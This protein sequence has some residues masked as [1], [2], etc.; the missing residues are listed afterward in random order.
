MTKVVIFTDLDGTLLDHR[1]YSFEKAMPALE[2]IRLGAAYPDLRRALLDLQREGFAV[3]G[4]GDM[5]P[6]EV[7]DITNLDINEAEMAKKRD[8][9][10]PF[11]YSGSESELAGLFD[12]I[13]RKGF[14]CT[15]GS[16]FH[17][18]GKSDKGIA[19]SI[20]AEL[21]RQEYGAV[22]TIALG[23]SPNDIPMLQNVDCPIVVQRPDSRYHPKMVMPNLIKA[24]GIGPE[25]WNRAVLKLME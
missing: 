5:T 16:F 4:F 12:A 19:V 22:R 15:E 20:L 8:F 18:L 25:G 9:D 14:T 1:T 23:D 21:Y 11:V 24:D 10:E 3:R 6:E 2:L 13:R 17:I 7:A